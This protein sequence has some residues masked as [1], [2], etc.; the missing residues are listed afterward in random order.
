MITLFVILAVYLLCG[1]LSYGWYIG[2]WNSL[3]YEVEVGIR[4]AILLS[5]LY[6]GVFSLPLV[7]KARLYYRRWNL[8]Y[9]TPIMRSNA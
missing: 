6:E 8:F 7:I 5:C 9:V 1:V 2:C 4:R 3:P